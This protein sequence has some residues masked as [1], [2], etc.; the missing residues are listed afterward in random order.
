M[1]GKWTIKKQQERCVPIRKH[2]QSPEI[3]LRALLV[4]DEEY[5]IHI[6]PIFRGIMEY[7]VRKIGAEMGQRVKSVTCVFLLG[8]T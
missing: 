3:V 4:N 1:V 2:R 6:K 5:L 8:G 7:I